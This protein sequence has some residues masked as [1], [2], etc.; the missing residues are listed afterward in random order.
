MTQSPDDQALINHLL[1]SGLEASRYADLDPGRSCPAT[2]YISRCSEQ[3]PVCSRAENM[4]ATVQYSSA[5]FGSFL[6]VIGIALVYART[7]ALNIAQAGHVFS[8]GHADGLVVV[9]LAFL[10]CGFLVKAP[11]ERGAPRVR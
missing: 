10:V 4:A 8:G 5:S 7:G 3:Q 11:K 6:A 1:L 2:P 9:A